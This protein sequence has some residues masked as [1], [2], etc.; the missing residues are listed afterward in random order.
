MSPRLT[1][2]LSVVALVIWVIVAFVQAIPAGWPH[3]FLVASVGL[4][5]YGI[6][7]RDT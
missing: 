6:A 5:V 2:L 7:R 3:L 1:F 4:A